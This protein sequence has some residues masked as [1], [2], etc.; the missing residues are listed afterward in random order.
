MDRPRRET[1]V[2]LHVIKMKRIKLLAV[3]SKHETDS[4]YVQSKTKEFTS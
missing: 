3:Q 2:N 4:F 1:W